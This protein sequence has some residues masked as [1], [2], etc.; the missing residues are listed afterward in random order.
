MG[1][2]LEIKKGRRGNSFFATE[3]QSTQREKNYEESRN[4]GILS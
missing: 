4:T 3:T 1:K 2:N